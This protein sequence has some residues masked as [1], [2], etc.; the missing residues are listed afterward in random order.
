MSKEPGAV[1]GLNIGLGLL[2]SSGTPLTTMAANPL[3]DNAGEIPEGPRG[4]GVATVDGLKRRTPFVTDFNVHA[5]YVIELGTNRIELIADVFNLFDTQSVLDYD[6]Y[7]D[8]SFFVSNPDFGNIIL[9]QVPRQIR[10][11]LR[12]RF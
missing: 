4:S 6:Y 1:H 12:F 5:D 2:A 11:G 10:L 8:T 9:Y 7:S 3:Y